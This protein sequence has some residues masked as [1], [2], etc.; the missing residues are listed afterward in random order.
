MRLFV[1]V[2]PC[3]CR[4]LIPPLYLRPAHLLAP[5]NWWHHR[6]SMTRQFLAAA[7][8]AAVSADFS[9]CAHTHT[10]ARAWFIWP[11]RLHAGHYGCQ[12]VDRNTCCVGLVVGFWIHREEM[13]REIDIKALDCRW[14]LKVKCLSHC[15]T[16]HCVSRARART[17]DSPEMEGAAT[18]ALLCG[19][20]EGGRGS[21]PCSAP[22]ECCWFVFPVLVRLSTKPAWLHFRSNRAPQII[23]YYGLHPWEMAFSIFFIRAKKKK[24][25]LQCKLW[26]KA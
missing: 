17:S 25:T 16:R 4:R 23:K 22:G 8:I 26:W 21:K 7:A 14:F 19:L 18:S 1:D 10:Q 6:K 3:I 9:C 13:A 12:N 5:P 11:A 2:P 20:L 24:K 15:D